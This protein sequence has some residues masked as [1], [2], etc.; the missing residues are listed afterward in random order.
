MTLLVT[1]LPGRAAT[2]PRGWGAGVVSTTPTVSKPFRPAVRGCP[3]RGVLSITDRPII[4]IGA[5]EGL[6]N[7][8]HDEEP[9]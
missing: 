9:G 8:T 5:R 7:S 4:V 6:G 2:S 1:A 3:R